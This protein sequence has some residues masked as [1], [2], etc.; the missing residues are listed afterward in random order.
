[1]P[2]NSSK[3][4]TTAVTAALPACT[5]SV[6]LEAR[7]GSSAIIAWAAST[8]A[9]SPG[10]RDARSSRLWATARIASMAARFSVSGSPDGVTSVGTTGG[11]AILATGPAATP[12]LTP[13]PLSVSAM[14]Y[15]SLSRS[16]ET[17]A[18]SSSRAWS[19]PSPSA[20]RTTSSPPRASRAS[21]DRMLRASTGFPPALAMVTFTGCLAAAWTNMA[22]GRAC[23]PTLEP[24]AT[25]RSGMW[26]LRLRHAGTTP[27][28]HV[29]DSIN[30]E[31]P[32]RPVR[33]HSP[34][35]ASLRSAGGGAE[36][37]LADVA[38]VVHEGAAPQEVLGAG[39]VVG[40][41][42]PTAR[43]TIAAAR[44]PAT[45]TAHDLDPAAGVSR[46]LVGHADGSAGVWR[47]PV[48]RHVWSR[49]V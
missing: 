1:M 9:A 40:D 19:A 18:A 41:L 37:G 46:R 44:R 15:P 33:P 8:L 29:P 28:L 38:L 17:R 12:G 43:R 32:R 39:A 48:I 45:G 42:R 47:L 4:S 6:T 16:L 30:G 27:A 34:A 25:R 24:T 35:S 7:V 2:R 23:R 13:M 11:G 3:A 21:T 10:A 36:G 5:P 22:A 26:N 14:G 49:D 20:D 31:A